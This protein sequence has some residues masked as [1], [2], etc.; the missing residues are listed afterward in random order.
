MEKTPDLEDLS[1]NSV[2]VEADSVKA[3]V[4][5]TTS[6]TTWQSKNNEEPEIHPKY[7]VQLFYYKSGEG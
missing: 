6:K 4:V 2:W 3:R 5:G 1:S 7:E